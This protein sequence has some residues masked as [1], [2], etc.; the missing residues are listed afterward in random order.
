MHDD[1]TFDEE[2]FY[3]C[4]KLL[5]RYTKA[6]KLGEGTFG[7]VEKGLIKAI[8]AKPLHRCPDWW[9]EQNGLSLLN[10]S[11][12][13]GKRKVKIG[14]PGQ[15]VAIKRIILHKEEDGVRV[16]CPRLHLLMALQMPITSLREIRALKLLDHPNIVPLYD[17]AYDDGPFDGDAIMMSY[18]AI[19]DERD[20]SKR[21]TIS[22][23]FPYMEHDLVGLL[24]NPDVKLPP[25]QL[26]LYAKQLL[27]GIFYLH[28]VCPPSVAADI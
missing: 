13:A 26:K 2:S 15:A 18:A 12:T 23:V 5:E 1:P 8:N 21:P 4:S 16:P 24:E 22:M 20:P 27:E 17:M 14:R 10:H 28:S 6:D 7:V 25:A 11:E 9:R 3:G 19:A